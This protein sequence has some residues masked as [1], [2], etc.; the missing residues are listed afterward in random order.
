MPQPEET[1]SEPEPEPVPVPAPE[2]EPEPTPAPEP[3]ST[4]TRIY[5]RMRAPEVVVIEP[6]PEPEPAPAVEASWCVQAVPTAMP[7]E[8]GYAYV[9]VPLPAACGTPYCLLGI[10]TEDNRVSAVRCAMPG[11]YSP[12]PPK[13]LEGSVWIGAGDGGGYW[14]FTVP[15]DA[16]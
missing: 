2:P 4:Q 13:G 3:E 6:E 12:T 8:D 14:V 1:V 15:C 5:T 7:L 16:D 11:P 9:R 10:K